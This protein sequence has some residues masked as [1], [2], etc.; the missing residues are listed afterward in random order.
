ME[1]L[2]DRDARIYERGKLLLQAQNEDLELFSQ[3]I[4]SPGLGRRNAYYLAKLD[5]VLGD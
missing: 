5:R 3:L 1:F 2:K 4:K